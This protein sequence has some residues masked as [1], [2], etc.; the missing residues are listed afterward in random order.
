[1]SLL[2]CSLTARALQTEAAQENLCELEELKNLREAGE[3][4]PGLDLD[5]YTLMKKSFISPL[6]PEVELFSFSLP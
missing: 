3:S 1:M 4:L 5:F 2:F 6:S